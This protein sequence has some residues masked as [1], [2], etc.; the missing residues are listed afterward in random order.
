MV[1]SLNKTSLDDSFKQ[2]YR[3]LIPRDMVITYRGCQFL[4]RKGH[5]DIYLLS[6]GSE[7][8][9]TDLFTPNDGD[10]VVDMGAHVGKFALPSAKSVGEDGQVFAF[11]AVPEHYNGLKR[12]LDLND[13]SNVT[14]INAATYDKNQEMWLVGWNLQSEPDQE[15]PPHEHVNPEGSIPVK[16]VTVDSVLREYEVQS[17]D[18]VKIDIGR[19]EVNALEGMKGTLQQSTEVTILVEISEDNFDDVDS[20]LTEMGFTGTALDGSWEPNGLRDYLYRKKAS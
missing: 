17:V 8:D 20:M 19:Q 15:H 1:A 13:F 18:Y 14:A 2:L 3:T 12:N 7:R 16:A 6:P 11:E 4:A 5:I 9:A 10:T